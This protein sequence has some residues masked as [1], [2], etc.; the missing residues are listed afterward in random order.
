[1]PNADDDAAGSAAADAD[2]VAAALAAGDHLV[3][4]RLAVARGEP[5]RALDIY[6]RLWRFADALPLALQLGRRPLAIRLALDLGDPR[7]AAEIAASIPCDASAELS[8]AAAAF[9]ARGRHLDAGH[10]A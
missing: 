1:M 3:A 5:A 6:D 9:A 8:A 7:R 10:L 2:P 4:A